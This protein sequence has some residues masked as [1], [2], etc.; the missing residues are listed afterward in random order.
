MRFILVSI[1][2]ML[3]IVAWAQDSAVT[4]NRPDAY[5][6]ISTDNAGVQILEIT[7]LKKDYPQELL[8]QQLATLGKEV[9]SE[10]RIVYAERHNPLT[11]KA[12]GGQLR[13]TAAVPGLIRHQESVLGLQALARAFAGAPSPNEVD[14]LMIQYA[15][16]VPTKTTIRDYNAP[17]VVAVTANASPQTG[18]EYRIAL[19]TQDPTKIII[20]EG[21]AAKAPIPPTKPVEKSGGVNLIVIFVV[22]VAALAVGALV[23]SLLLRPKPRG[24][25][26]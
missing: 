12:A 19:L 10:P 14:G 16:E 2:L 1:A 8:R 22:I 6:K 3:S 11:G 5:I 23:Y 20:P 21:Q 18:V 13:V 4:S 7:M 25:P 26:R 17:G 24:G 15:K 9:G